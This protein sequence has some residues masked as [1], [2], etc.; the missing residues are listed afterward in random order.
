MT[1]YQALREAAAWLD[2]SAR[3]RIRATGEDRVRL[4]HAMCTNHIQNLQ[5]GEGCYA[6]FL[7][8]QGR[9]LADAQILA[10]P[11]ALLIDTE[12]ETRC[13]LYAHLDK[14][15]IADD[16]SLEDTTAETV[17]IGIEGPQAAEVLTRLG[18]P[19]PAS[20]YSHLAWG[21]GLVIRFSVT[22]QPG[23][24]IMAPL[25]RRETLIRDIEAAGA[26]RAS[27]QE[28]RA[29]RLERG[30]PRYGEDITDR[31][32]PHETQ[33]LGAL[34]FTKGCYLGQEIVERVRSR[35]GV[36]RF[37]VPLE[38]EGD[39]PLEP[40]AVISA[41]GT[42][43][44]ELTSAAWSPSLGRMVALGYLRL[45]DIPPGAALACAGR[46]VRLKAAQAGG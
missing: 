17:A 1:G 43:V 6:F 46:P 33:L 11:E 26:V 12:P 25:G 44:G 21:D 28:A 9:I 3:G 14:Y 35:G 10:L 41:E 5:P 30:H 42:A 2:L 32:L 20:L 37:L 13:S 18:A 16:V 40:G 19:L 38:I 45:P 29:V 4:L 15:I 27:D 36:H 7:N 23:F 39:D 22:G 34:H 8:A 31:N 24:S